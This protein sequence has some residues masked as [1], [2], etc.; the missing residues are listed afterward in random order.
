MLLTKDGLPSG[1]L[2]NDWRLEGKQNLFGQLNDASHF[3][4][5]VRSRLRYGRLRRT[6]LRLLR[7][8][9]SAEAVECDWVARPTPKAPARG[10]SPAQ[11]RHASLQTLRD[12][13]EI[14]ALIFN[15]IPDAKEA[16]F[17]VFRMLPDDSLELV[18]TGLTHRVDHSSRGLRSVVMKAKILGFQFRLEEDRLLKI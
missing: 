17:R 13:I 16:H 8:Q 4:R 12:A 9:L 7:F 18:L 3:L 2:E 6:P 11:H 1:P 10:F 5:D 15:L 14:R